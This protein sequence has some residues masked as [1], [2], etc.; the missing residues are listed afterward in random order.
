MSISAFDS[1][2]RVGCSAFVHPGVDILT[3]VLSAEWRKHQGAVAQ[4]LK[5]TEVQVDQGS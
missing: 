1:A 2:V 5:R 3:I 4:N